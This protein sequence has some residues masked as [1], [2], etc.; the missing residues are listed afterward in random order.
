MEGPGLSPCESEA[1]LESY[2]ADKA[3]TSA[4]IRALCDPLLRQPMTWFNS[5]VVS[6]S[7]S[8]IDKGIGGS[9]IEMLITIP[10]V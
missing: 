9:S 3:K 2:M 8:K 4:D 5:P 1:L 6:T 7:L 10:K